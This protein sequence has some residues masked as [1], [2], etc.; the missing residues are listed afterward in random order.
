MS[1]IDLRVDFCSHEAAKYAVEKW[2][3]TATMPQGR[4][5]YWG[6]WEN[7]KY[8]GCV[9]YGFSIS[10]QL[11]KEFDLTQH[12]VTELKRVALNTHQSFVSQVVAMTLRQLKTK[13]R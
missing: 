10:P 12:E 7:G 2:H 9:I 11:G 8:I 4:N 3:Y 6:V 1:K 13:K 5:N